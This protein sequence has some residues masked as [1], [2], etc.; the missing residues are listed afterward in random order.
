MV[1][2]GHERGTGE[3][4]DFGGIWFAKTQDKH[5]RVELVRPP[6]AGGHSFIGPKRNRI[7]FSWGR[8]INEMLVR[9]RRVC[10]TLRGKSVG[11]GEKARGGS[12]ARA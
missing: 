3:I 1:A 8:G 7:W 12:F 5:W 6:G 10:V 4:D 2:I 9:V 11:S